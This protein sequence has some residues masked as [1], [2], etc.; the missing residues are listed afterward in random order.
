MLNKYNTGSKRG[1]VTAKVT[2]NIYKKRKLT[3]VR[4]YL[5]PYEVKS[6][7][8]NVVPHDEPR[9]KK[10]SKLNINRTNWKMIW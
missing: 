4:R 9:N 6:N 7:L 8:G 5:A 10:I 3:S 2:V 1:L